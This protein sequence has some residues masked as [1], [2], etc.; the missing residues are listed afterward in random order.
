MVIPEFNSVVASGQTSCGSF[1]SLD[2]ED[3]DDDDDDDDDTST[4]LGY[5]SLVLGD[6]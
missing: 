2:G 4:S 5:T 3:N 6:G 1:V